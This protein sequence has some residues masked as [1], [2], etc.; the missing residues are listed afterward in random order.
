[1]V[2]VARYGSVTRAA[3]ALHVSHSSI[4]HQLGSLQR[5]ASGKIYDRVDH[6][7]RLTK[8]GRKFARKSESILTQF[9][10]LKDVLIESGKGRPQTLTVGGGHGTS[11][12]VLSALLAKYYQAYP[13]TKPTLRTHGTRGIEQM[14]LRSEIDIGFVTFSPNSSLLAVEPFSEDE[15]VPFASVKHPLA[16]RSKVTLEEFACASL[17]VRQ[18]NGG[19]E[20]VEK[21][22]RKIV[23]P[24][25]KLNILARCASSEAV[26]SAVEAGGSVGLLSLSQVKPGVKE[27][28]LKILRVPGLAI[29]IRRF[30]IYRK[31]R[32]LSPAARDFLALMRAN[33]PSARK[34]L[35]VSEPSGRPAAKNRRPASSTK[36]SPRIA[37]L[38][39]IIFPLLELLA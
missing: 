3:A 21:S 6:G 4:S 13:L 9:E 35:A 7:V 5:E 12:T 31:D 23:G 16:K 27:G 29:K 32:P 37:A 39:P 1:M 36:T 30:I 22:L 25:R 38:A 33:K 17:I 14:L 19:K 8:A 2:A 20:D 26:K 24:K 11:G 28:K 18:G 10:G 15:V 34:Q